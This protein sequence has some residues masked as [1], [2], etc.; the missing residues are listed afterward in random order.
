MTELGPMSALKR[1]LAR[2]K[3]RTYGFIAIF[4]G[5]IM[6]SYIAFLLF[7][8]LISSFIWTFFT[9]TLL[10]QIT[11]SLGFKISKVAQ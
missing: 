11:V 3:V 7:Y 2:E 4:L 6:L 9:I 8:P 5:P 1:F 10:R